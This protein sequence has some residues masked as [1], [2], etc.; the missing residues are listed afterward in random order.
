M[1]HGQFQTKESILTC[2]IT[3]SIQR[4]SKDQA[5]TID[6]ISVR[7]QQSFEDKAKI[8]PIEIKIQNNKKFI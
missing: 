8:N 3:W 1:R 5:E 7:S 2:A 6:F 4:R